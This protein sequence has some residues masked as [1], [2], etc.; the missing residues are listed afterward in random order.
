MFCLVSVLLKVE[1]PRG[2]REVEGGVQTSDLGLGGMVWRNS[3][4][5]PAN[6]PTCRR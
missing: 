4:A 3:L 6:V 5:G 1:D 2:Q